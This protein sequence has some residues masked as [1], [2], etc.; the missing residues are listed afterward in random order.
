MGKILLLFFGRSSYHTGKKIALYKLWR[1]L[2]TL[3][4]ALHTLWRVDCICTQKESEDVW[5]WTLVH[6]HHNQSSSSLAL[7]W[8]TMFLSQVISSSNPSY[9]KDSNSITSKEDMKM[10]YGYKERRKTQEKIMVM[11]MSVLQS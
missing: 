1:G 9:T 6:H 4:R 7:T 3:I 2:K 8:N 11:M 10:K 5:D